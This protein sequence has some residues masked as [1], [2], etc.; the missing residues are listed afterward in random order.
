MPKLSE[1]KASHNYLTI[2]ERDFHGLPVL[3][4]ADFSNNQIIALGREL[5]SRTKCKIENGVHE[6]TWDTL[7]IYL[8]GM[9]V[10]ENTKKHKTIRLY[11]LVIMKNK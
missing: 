8:Q 10:V 4:H 6:G 11:I 9:S 5:V 3:C 2:L 7:K 1:L